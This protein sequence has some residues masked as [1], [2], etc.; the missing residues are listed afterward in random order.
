MLL[1]CILFCCAVP[2]LRS[3]ISR[4]IDMQKGGIYVATET[5]PGD[6]EEGSRLTPEGGETD[7][8]ALRARKALQYDWNDQNEGCR[9]ECGSDF[10]NE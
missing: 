5:L 4:A 10:I 8:F 3:M 6:Q 1:C 9:G 2:I 7:V